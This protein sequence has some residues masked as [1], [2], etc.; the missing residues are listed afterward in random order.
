VVPVLVRE[1]TDCAQDSNVESANETTSNL[2]SEDSL[3][4]LEV[5]L[6]TFTLGSLGLLLALYC[7][8]VRVGDV[9][10]CQLVSRH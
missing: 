1:V 2:G 9:S 3:L 6:R 8:E 5:K 4:G 7:G 10:T